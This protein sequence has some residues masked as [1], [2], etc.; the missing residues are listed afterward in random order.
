MKLIDDDDDDGAISFGELTSQTQMWSSSTRQAGGLLGPGGLPARSGRPGSSSGSS[1]RRTADVTTTI[2]KTIPVTP[3]GG[4]GPQFRRTAGRAAASSSSGRRSGAEGRRP[5]SGSRLIHQSIGVRDHATMRTTTATSADMDSR[6]AENNAEDDSE[7]LARVEG[8][9]ILQGLLRVAVGRSEDFALLHRLAASLS[10]APND[11]TDEQTTK[12][13]APA[14]VEQLLTECQFREE[15]RLERE[16][17]YMDTIDEQQLESVIAADREQYDTLAR[18]LKKSSAPSSSSAAREP[19]RQA[20]AAGTPASD[21]DKAVS[22]S[23]STK[24][25]RKSK[26]ERTSAGSALSAYLEN[27]PALRMSSSRVPRVTTSHGFARQS[28]RSRDLAEN[29]YTPRA[30]ASG[31][32]R[33]FQKQLER[34]QTAPSSGARRGH[35]RPSSALSRQ[36]PDFVP[37]HESFLSLQSRLRSSLRY[38]AV[39]SRDVMLR[40]LPNLHLFVEG[41]SAQLTFYACVY[42]FRWSFLVLK[43]KRLVPYTCTYNGNAHTLR[44]TPVAI[45]RMTQWRPRRSYAIASRRRRIIFGTPS[46]SLRNQCNVQAARAGTLTTTTVVRLRRTA[47]FAESG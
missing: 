39:V 43:K 10:T 42:S 13:F 46:R 29:V 8:R 17:E 37:R 21:A 15:W 1:R 27:P 28:S 45:S 40:C 35:G 38:E 47:C 22:S 9:M 41:E 3:T 5:Q 18:Q 7:M 14:V 34:P 2:G 19:V 26:S 44:V 16:K 36:R 12:R 20:R 32:P 24:P 4:E 31:K 6:A 23:F 30:S 25:R 33:G 11:G